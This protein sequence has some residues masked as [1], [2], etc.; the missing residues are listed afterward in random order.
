MAWYFKGYSVGGEFRA[1][2]AQV[3]NLDHMDEILATLD[4]ESPYP[5]DDAE[6]PRGRLGG[7]K[8]CALPENW[9]DSRDLVGTERA[10]L[11][12]AELSV[13]GG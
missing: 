11:L 13:S 12:E 4:R 7:A 6:G 3:Q 8:S 10:A 5:G 9:L 2:L 1:T